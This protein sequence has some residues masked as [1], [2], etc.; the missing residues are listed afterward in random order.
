MRKLFYQILLFSFL[1]TGLLFGVDNYE[2][3]KA[4]T[5]IGFS[6]K[7][8]V[9]T[10]VKGKFKDYSGTIILDENNW[11]NSS[12]DVTIKTASIDTDNERRDEHL[13]SSDFFLVNEYPDITFKS[14]SIQKVGENYLAKGVLTM[15]GVS[16][17]IDLPFKIIGKVKNS[18]GNTK[19]GV[20][21]ELVINRQDFGVSWNRTL[22]SGGLVVSDEVK[23]ELDIQLL[24]K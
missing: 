23:I 24:K 10:N 11:S 18:R 6:V 7:H 3:D 4:H 12:I 20:E 9:I 14:N 21:S 8:M 2:F 19:L 15:R 5:N 16:K 22:D 17:K 1:I 13:R